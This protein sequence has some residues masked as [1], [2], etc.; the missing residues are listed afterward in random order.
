VIPRLRSIRFRL[1]L[2]YG[3][4]FLLCA[5]VLLGITVAL[6]NVRLD[7][8]APPPPRADSPRHSTA[9][10]AAATGTTDQSDGTTNQNDTN[11]RE[12]Q[13]R[14]DRQE[15]QEELRAQTVR[16]AVLVSGFTLAGMVVVSFG[17][18]WVVAGR[19]LRPIHDITDT[20]R[21]LS[22]ENLHERIALSGPPDELKQLADTFDSMLDRLDTAFRAQKEF[23]ANASHELRTPLALIATEVDVA[24]DDPDLD[25]AEYAET[26][27]AVRAAVD[28]AQ[29][30]I[31]RLLV[32]ARAEGPAA[33]DRIDLAETT[34]N[35]L[36]EA[37]RT[38]PHES[39][40]VDR[41]LLPAV[42]RGDEPLLERLVGN[43]VENAVRYNQPDGWV[44]VETAMHGARARL[45][46]ANSGE[47]VPPE[48]VAAL[49]GRFERGDRGRDR[50]SG[51]FGLG[52]A[53]VQAVAIAH[54]GSVSAEA[55]DEGGLAVTVD[56]PAGEPS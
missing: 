32:L 34:R 45:R 21:R 14:E 47:Q 40:R 18:G 42:V 38:S 17:L 9:P 30:L 11:D 35:A 22:D 55:L 3:G 26:L 54:G 50:R 56:L 19:M 31:D 10:A 33:T 13:R 41:D 51:G 7:R 27:T 16:S 15:I 6:I 29:E 2:V 28:R 36:D 37:L 48:Q 43:L 46:V 44:R 53:I 23:V 12:R 8:Q 20:A 25:P 1:T 49:F 4:M 39:L 52:L 24:L 5:V